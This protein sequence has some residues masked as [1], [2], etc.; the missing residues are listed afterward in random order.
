MKSNIYL[1]TYPSIYHLP[2]FPSLFLSA[3]A[4]FSLLVKHLKYTY[5]I[6]FNVLDY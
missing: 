3:H 2:N 1:S 6:C 4:F 5:N